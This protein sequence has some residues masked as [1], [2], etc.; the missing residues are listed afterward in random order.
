MLDAVSEAQ[1]DTITVLVFFR[2]VFVALGIE[3]FLKRR[4]VQLGLVFRFFCLIVAFYAA[5]AVYGV[6]APGATMWER[7]Q[8]C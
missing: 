4:A 3:R 5:I 6:Q 7:Q 8:F 1:R 2:D